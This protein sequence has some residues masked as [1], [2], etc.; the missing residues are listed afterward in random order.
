MQV[1]IHSNYLEHA[2]IDSE[3]SLY[4]IFNNINGYIKESNGDKYLIFV[5][6]DKNKEILEKQAKLWSEIKNQIKTINGG[7]PFK[8]KKDFI[9]IGFESDDALPLD[10]ILSIPSMIIVTRS[11]LQE[12]NKYYPQVY[13]H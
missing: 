11:V 3:N 10:K 2:N 7:E 5:S 12:G 4:F 6:T 13:L 9:K 1:T 8:Y